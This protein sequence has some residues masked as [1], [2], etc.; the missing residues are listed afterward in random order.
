M[1]KKS[2]KITLVKTTEEKAVRVMIDIDDENLSSEN[3]F[4]DTYFENL[5][6]IGIWEY[7]HENGNLKSNINYDLL[8]KNNNKR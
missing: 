3:L 6:K 8:D 1:K 2:N 7:Y 5:L 4:G